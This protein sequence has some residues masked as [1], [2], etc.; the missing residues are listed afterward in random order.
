MSTFWSLAT[1]MVLLAFA[2]ILPPLLRTRSTLRVDQDDLNTEVARQRLAELEQDLKTGRLHQAQY[3]AARQDLEQE[4]LYDIGS[5]ER[6]DDRQVRSGRWAILLLAVAVPVCATLLYQSLGSEQIITLLQTRPAVQQA[7]Q[8]APPVDSVEEMADRLA[9][10]LQNEPDN[11]DGWVMLAKTYNVL[12]RFD[13]AVPAYR[14]IMRLGGDN[15]AALLADFADALVTTSNGIFNDETGGLLTNALQLEPDNVKALWLAGHWK[16][17]SGDTITAIRHWQQAS[18]LM[19]PGS[20]DK[21][22]IDRQIQQTRQQAELPTTDLQQTGTKPTTPA[23]PPATGGSALQ[24]TVS[25]DQSLTDK[26]NAEDTVFIYARA[27]KGP[28][29]PLAIA[30]KQVRELPVT[31]TLDDSMA[32]A[33]GM[34]LSGFQEVT[35]GARISKSGNAMAQSGDLQ[36]S[37][38]PVR[39]A[40]TA[41]IDIVIDSTVP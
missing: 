29:M 19:Q 28:R 22:T 12:G 4:L 5:S 41:S 40:D 10:R 38:T 9:V 23:S 34:L 6:N 2:F 18:N 7:Q 3:E 39:P 15:N 17:Q 11:L 32:M 36:G 13:L 14:N 33:P 25:L 30:R 35:V 27:A 21:M 31:V 20:Q 1:T 26:A 24:V 8:Q 16:K 37:K